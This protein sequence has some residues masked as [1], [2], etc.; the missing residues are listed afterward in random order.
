MVG[1]LVGYQGLGDIR[2]PLENFSCEVDGIGEKWGGLTFGARR[3]QNWYTPSDVY[4]TYPNM[5]R[6]SIESGYKPHMLLY[7]IYVFI[8]VNIYQEGS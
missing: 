3:A 7:G 2:V 6:I 4:D 5:S 8:Y 1:I